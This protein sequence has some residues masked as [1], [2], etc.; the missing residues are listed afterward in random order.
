M[1]NNCIETLDS[2]RSQGKP[3]ASNLLIHKLNE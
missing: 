2:L 1:K 3:P